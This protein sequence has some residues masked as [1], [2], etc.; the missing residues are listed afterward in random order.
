M[1]YT[2][3]GHLPKP[4]NDVLEWANWY[5]ST[6]RHVAKDEQNGI[7]VSTVFL[8]L[9]HSFGGGPPI[10]FETMIFGGKHDED[11]WHYATWEDAED[12]HK[13]AC[14]LAGIPCSMLFSMQA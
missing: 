3:D 11:Q 14:A 4:C 13:K 10:L 2:L 1:Q 6:D 9:D 8:G 7:L 5:Q 12:G